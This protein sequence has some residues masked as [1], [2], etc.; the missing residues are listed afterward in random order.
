[1]QK[2]KMEGYFVLSWVC[3][4]VLKDIKDD[5]WEEKQAS[6]SERMYEMTMMLRVF[7]AVNV[8][9][10]C[11]DILSAIQTLSA[12]GNSLFLVNQNIKFVSQ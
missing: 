3:A 8:E 11:F 2:E 9:S 10:G 12:E 4:L 6:Y 1:M 7:L 5:L